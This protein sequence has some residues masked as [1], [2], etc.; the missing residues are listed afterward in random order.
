MYAGAV[1]SVQLL[2]CKGVS[3]LLE[4]AYIAIV[5]RCGDERDF[6]LTS[7]RVSSRQSAPHPSVKGPVTNQE[8]EP[9]S[10]SQKIQND[11]FPESVSRQERF[12]CR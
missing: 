1:L 4:R 12:S 10:H 6:E 3:I 8:P 5:R 9:G 11:P 2:F 7:P